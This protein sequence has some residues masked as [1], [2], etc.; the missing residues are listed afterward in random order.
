[1]TKF[2]IM[3]KKIEKLQIFLILFLVT[4]LGKLF[5][6]FFNIFEISIKS[7]ILDTS[8]EII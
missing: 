7:G 3:S 5:C 6:N 4:F 2:M 8:T 1:M